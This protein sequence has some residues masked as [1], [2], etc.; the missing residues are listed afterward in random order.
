MTPSLYIMAEIAYWSRAACF[1]VASVQRER[2]TESETERAKDKTYLL[3]YT[4]SNIFP[5]A[6][7]H[8]LIDLSAAVNPLIKLVSD[9]I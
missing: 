2:E 5:S 9:L 7:L 8:L 3:K 4:L 6:R 1:I